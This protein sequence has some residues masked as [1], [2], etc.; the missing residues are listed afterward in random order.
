MQK[1]AHKGI[2]S[3]WHYESQRHALARQGIKTGVKHPISFAQ[4][5]SKNL[6]ELEINK[7]LYAPKEDAVD[8]EILAIEIPR[9]KVHH[10]NFLKAFTE[11]NTT[12][13]WKNIKDKNVQ[14]EIEF[15]DSKDE[16][17]GKQLMNFLK[18][19]N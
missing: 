4:P 12:G 7:I 8:R 18:K 17:Y 2:G 13:V 5:F 19:L 9:S 15:R 6:T 1:Y 11:F 10:L 3:G 16:R 14:F